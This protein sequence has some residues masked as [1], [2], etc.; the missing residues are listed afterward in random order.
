MTETKHMFGFRY[1]LKS[2]KIS[3][4]DRD[5]YVEKPNIWFIIS[6]IVNRR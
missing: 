3:L 5:Y 1:L 4:V 2:W 6:H